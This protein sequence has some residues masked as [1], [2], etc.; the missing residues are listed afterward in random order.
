[1]SEETLKIL[2]PAFTGL[3]GLFIGYFLN[4]ALYKRKRDD[5]LADR[6]FN[7][8]AAIWD[9]RIK[10]AREVVESLQMGIQ[11]MDDLGGI[12]SPETFG[13]RLLQITGDEAY[14]NLPLLLTEASRKA[15]SIKILNDKPLTDLNWEL[16]ALLIPTSGKIA[17]A[18]WNFSKGEIYDY[19]TESKGIA[20]S[21]EKAFAVITKMK[22]RLDILAQ[23]VP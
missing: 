3:L 11:T 19:K 21:A 16:A 7:R 9:M 15:D 1:M 23:K 17:N 12:T 10:E 13:A 2:I 18:L 5:E 8:R 14:R 6:D 22:A 20:E 4:Q